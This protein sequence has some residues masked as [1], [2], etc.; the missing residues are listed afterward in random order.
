MAVP[1]I[2]AAGISGL[3]GEFSIGGVGSLAGTGAASGSGFGGILLGQI[4]NLNASQNTAS[5]D[6]VALATG[7]ATDVSAVVA[8]VEKASLEMQLAVQVRD[9]AVAAYQSLTQMQM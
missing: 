6:S 2:T 7:Q 4:A 3:G 5:A 1:P 8:A 9:R